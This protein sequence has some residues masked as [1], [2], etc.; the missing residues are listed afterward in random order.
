MEN[1]RRFKMFKTKEELANAFIKESS[2]FPY[3]NEHEE[4]F[5][6]I[7]IGDGVKVAFKSF[8]ERVEFYKKQKNNPVGTLFAQFIDDKD[9][10]KDW[11]D[12]LFDFCFG[13]IRGD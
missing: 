6:Q 1:I 10:R 4:Q 7:G 12:W 2:R 11:K 8:A 5:Y 13:D 9:D 3:A